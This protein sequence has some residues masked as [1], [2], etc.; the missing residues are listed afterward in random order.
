MSNEIEEIVSDCGKYN[1]QVKCVIVVIDKEHAEKLLANNYDYNRDEKQRYIDKYSADMKNKEFMLSP[2]AITIDKDGRLINGQ[3]R[4]LAVV[5]SG[6][7][8][9]FIVM[10]NAP[11]ETKDIINNGNP[12]TNKDRAKMNLEEIGMNVNRNAWGMMC[13]C[14]ALASDGRKKKQDYTTSVKEVR[15]FAEKNKA[16]LTQILNRDYGLSNYKGKQMKHFGIRNVPTT[17]AIEFELRRRN[18]QYAKEFFDDIDKK[19]MPTGSPIG[20]LRDWMLNETIEHRAWHG[21]DAGEIAI[22]IAYD[23]YVKW[24]NGKKNPLNTIEVMT[25]AVDENGNKIVDD[26]G[27]AIKVFRNEFRFVEYMKGR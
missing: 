25:S 19:N 17:M 21:T 18:A 24:K 7:P 3:H 14:L 22:M 26:E 10:Y 23:A 27:K 15:E 13:E 9:P 8:Q 4:L 12:T 6:I 11:T 1:G 2:D 16:V 20:V 5:E